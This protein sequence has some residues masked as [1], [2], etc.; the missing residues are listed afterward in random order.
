[1]RLYGALCQDLNGDNFICY[2]SF[3]LD[4]LSTYSDIYYT[5]R[6]G[7]DITDIYDPFEDNTFADWQ[8]Y[9]CVIKEHDIYLRGD[10]YYYEGD[11]PV[12]AICGERETTYEEGKLIK[13]QFTAY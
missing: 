7:A 5:V 10:R 11:E 9:N 8:P 12:N 6:E 1:M 3:N 4:D 13:Q 2:I